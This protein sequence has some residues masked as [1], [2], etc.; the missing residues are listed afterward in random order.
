MER[1]I[2]NKKQKQEMDRIVKFFMECTEPISDRDERG[3]V[4]AKIL[5][6]LGCFTD[7]LTGHLNKNQKWQK[8]G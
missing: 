4:T 2:L 3:I 6:H 7:R 8:C 1:M 5:S